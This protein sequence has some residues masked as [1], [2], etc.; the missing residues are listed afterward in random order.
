MDLLN[1]RFF[2]KK[3]LYAFALLAVSAHNVQGIMVTQTTNG[4]STQNGKN[5]TQNSDQDIILFLK[6]LYA[7]IPSC[8]WN[9][10]IK[11][12][13][14]YMDDYNECTTAG[15]ETMGYT[16]ANDLKEN[17]TLSE[18]HFFKTL[19]NLYN[20]GFTPSRDQFERIEKIV[21]RVIKE[22][23]RSG[24]KVKSLTKQRDQEVED[25]KNLLEKIYQNFLDRSFAVRGQELD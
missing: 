9:S 11:Q 6:N 1:W 7:T 14:G 25:L 2:M 24:I 18:N 4:T 21:F 8:P 19:E 23:Y 16:Y 10:S 22:K 20:T 3:S 13:P 12:L 5:N 17:P 15:I